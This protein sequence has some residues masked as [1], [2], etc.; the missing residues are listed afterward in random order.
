MKDGLNTNNTRTLSSITY[1]SFLKT[2]LDTDK[3]IGYHLN[4][5]HFKRIKLKIDKLAHKVEKFS[6]KSYLLSHKVKN[7]TKKNI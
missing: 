1:K 2:A 4:C 7:E 3:L 5:N 6:L